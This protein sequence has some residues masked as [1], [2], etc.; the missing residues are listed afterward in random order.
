MEDSY[1]VI[2]GTHVDND[3]KKDVVIELLTALNKE[4]I[5]VCLSTHSDYQLSEFIDL[6]DYIVYD[7]KNEFVYPS[8]LYKNADILSSEMPNYGYMYFYTE[9]PFGRISYNWSHTYH[10]KAA[11]TLLRNGIN[12]AYSNRYKWVV[13]IEYDIPIPIDGYKKF[14]EDKIE[15]LNRE[16][17]KCLYYKNDLPG[18]DFMWGGFMLCDTDSIYQSKLL[19]HSDWI[20]NKREWIKIWGLSFF[21]YCLQ[22]ALNRQF[23][24]NVLIK[25]VIEETIKSWGTDKYQ[26]LSK[27][28]GNDFTIIKDNVFIH[29]LPSLNKDMDYELCLFMISKQ[30]KS[31]LYHLKITIDDRTILQLEY[32]E[33]PADNWFL[34][35][36]PFEKTDETVRLIYTI[37]SNGEHSTKVEKFDIKNLN[38]IYTNIA[39]INYA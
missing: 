1:L 32:Q 13:Y 38:S 4:D 11:L 26:S 16:N 37:N 35:K 15:E 2:V 10:S 28:H 29:I 12:I 22:A 6:V 14:I 5:T 31:E 27:S 8:D 34:H 7:Y 18:I 17:K 33:L 25:P 19:I 39:R 9:Y 3:Y 20:K 23:D 24:N 21:E 36:I 30:S